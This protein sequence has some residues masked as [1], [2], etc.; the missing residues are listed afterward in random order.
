MGQTTDVTD[1]L[2]AY[3]LTH[4]LTSVYPLSYPLTYLIIFSVSLVLALVVTP[5]AGRLGRR[6]SIVDRPGGRRGHKG[7]VPRLG[8]I[9]LFVPFFA[10]I[11]VAAW[12]RVLTLGYS[13]ED[14]TRLNGLLIGGLGAF[15]FGLLDDRFD[16]P[17]GPQLAFQFLLSLVALA[18]L[19]WLERFTLPFLGYVELEAYPWGPWVYVPLTVLW[20]MG[21]MNTV[22]WLDGLDGL[23]AGVGAILCLVLAI[24]M[25]RVGQPSVALLPLALL[26]ALLGF[27]PYNVAPS[28]VFLG[29]AGA[30]F[31][32]YALGCLGLIAGGRVAT[33]L[34]VM[35]LPIVDVAWQIFDRLRH[36][37]SPAEAD[38]GHL[39]FRL[40]DLGLSKRAIVLIYWGFCG[41]FGVLALAVSSRVYK[42]LALAGIGVVVVV[43]LAFLSRVREE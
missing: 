31:L 36:R 41:L 15:L 16:L 8:G 33:V 17:P 42:L 5:L 23:A 29:S 18:T 38:R 32:G 24:H 25:H 40:L 43:V 3:P 26:G 10:A 14:F 9:P 20:T 21:M 12:C 22:N 28:R 4:P 2:S 39:H 27:L 19:L 1:P 6:L 37:R 35:G 30:F 13:A 34:L 7:E 11:G